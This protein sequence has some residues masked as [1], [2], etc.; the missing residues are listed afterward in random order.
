MDIML[1][2]FDAEFSEYIKNWLLEKKDTYKDMDEVEIMM[3]KLYFAWLNKPQEFL[4]GKK[5]VEYFMGFDA[6][7][8]VALMIRYE[9]K[10]IGIP[11]PLID[12]ITSKKKESLQYLCEIV[13]GE[14]VIPKSADAVAIQ[15]TAL[16]LI[17]EIDSSRYTNEYIEYISRKKIDEGVAESMVDSIKQHAKSHKVQLVTALENTDSDSAKSKLLDILC[18]L[19]YEEKVYNELISMFKSS[20]EKALYAS[21]LGKYGQSEAVKTL[22][23]SLDWININYLD[24]IE[25][26]N[27]I[28]ELGD[29][30]S[31][32]RNFEGDKFY[33]SMKGLN[34][35]S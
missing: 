18:A 29:E 25:I 22:R 19:P 4:S 13:F 26:R 20:S 8:L 11:D 23:E 27:A 3:P 15:I 33:E 12:A 16:N 24:Y 31:H 34:D 1:I 28:E 9:A 5:P 7:D 6:K 2:D 14:N 10:R 17:N 30:T 21:Y 35:D 32:A